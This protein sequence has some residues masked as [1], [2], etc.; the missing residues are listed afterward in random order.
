MKTNLKFFLVLLFLVFNKSTQERMPNIT[1]ALKEL[2]SLQILPQKVVSIFFVPD[3]ESVGKV[4]IC[5]EFKYL[6]VIGRNETGGRDD[7]APV[8]QVYTWKADSLV[9]SDSLILD[10]NL[11]NAFPSGYVPL[12][13]W[14][15]CS[16]QL[17]YIQVTG[18]T[19]SP[20]YFFTVKNGKLI[21]LLRERIEIVNG[22]EYGA[23][24]VNCEILPEGYVIEGPYHND[25]YCNLYKFNYET[26]SLE[27]IYSY[28]TPPEKM[29]D[30]YSFKAPRICVSQYLNEHF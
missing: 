21:N 20:S 2:V 25:D 3:K 5:N 6:V 24:C 1:K 8:V 11:S 7:F 26:L 4:T 15:Y 13:Y 28:E 14:G 10:Y 18:A 19:F 9:L 30:N 27:K 12:D 22:V 16:P 23:E 17:I 29:G